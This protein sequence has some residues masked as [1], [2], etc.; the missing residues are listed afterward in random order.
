MNFE[1]ILSI[2]V[3]FVLLFVMIKSADLIEETFVFLSSKV[4]LSTFFTGFV[5]LGATSNLPELAIL[6]SSRGEAVPLSVANLLGSSLISFTLIL[7]LAVIKLNGMHFKG[8]FTNKE[9][10]LCLIAIQTMV[11][12][13]LDGV[14][15][16]L[17]SI[18]LIIFYFLVVSHIYRNFIK[19][20]EEDE[21]VEFHASE[22]KLLRLG[23]KALLGI[24]L[25]LISSSLLVD[26]VLRIG[27]QLGISQTVLGIVI[28]SVGTNLPEITILFRAKNYNQRKLA[29][30]NF[31]GS[32]FVIVFLMGILGL[33]NFNNVIIE[34]I[35][36]LL[37]VIVITTVS[38][39]FFALFSFTGKK[40]TK[41]EGFFLMMLFA[42]LIFIEFL[43][44]MG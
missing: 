44:A 3:V 27:T 37:P 25:L 33:V 4:R 40:L 26:I 41:Y 39:L 31:L 20:N 42:L 13:F 36:E 34:D 7:G 16:P 10:I 1:F 23:T 43:G 30:G 14:L 22:Q 32:S 24:V 6:F 9:N 18:V 17:E 35:T 2:L 8:R 38:V 15:S 11:F 21:I 28:L 12:T 19:R 5:I 29:F